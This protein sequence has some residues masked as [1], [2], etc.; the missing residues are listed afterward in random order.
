MNIFSPSN[1]QTEPNSS[2][3]KLLGDEG[4]REV[5][6]QPQSLP[7]PAEALVHSTDSSVSYRLFVVEAIFIVKD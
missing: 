3:G 7:L 1:I 4:W 5:R 2:A 6:K